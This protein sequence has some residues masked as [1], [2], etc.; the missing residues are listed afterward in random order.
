M[1]QLSLKIHGQVHGVFF[2][3]KAKEKAQ[4]LDLVG[5]VKNSHDGTVE[6]VAEGG[7]AELKK[8]LEWCRIGPRL[9]KIERVEEGWKDVSNLTFNSFNIEY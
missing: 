1:K 5:W 4:A 3:V 6:V 2:R 8:L 7:E 9:A